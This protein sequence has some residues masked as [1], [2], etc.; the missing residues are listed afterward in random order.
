MRK[1]AA[2]PVSDSA[3]Q[4]FPRMAEVAKLAGVTVM[5][6]SRALRSPEKVAPDTLK[7]IRAAINTT[8][9]VPNALA[10]ALS[11][12]GGSRTITALIP[13]VQHAIFADTITGL[14]TVLRSEGYYLLLGETGYRLEE[15]D[16]LVAAF[17]ARRPE[18]FMLTG[19]THS[20]RTR[21]LLTRT[22]VP[23]VETWE[24][25]NSPIDMVVGYSNEKAAHAMTIWLAG[26]GYRRIAFV[27]GPSRTNER[28][29]RREVGYRRALKELGLRTLR[30]AAI[31]APAA[32]RLEDG[33]AILT[34]VLAEKP[35]AIFFTSDIYAVGAIQEAKR[36]KI[37]VP[38]DLG[39]AG[40]HDLP[41]ASVISPSLTTVHVPS[42]EIGCIAGR[43]IIARI[44]K[45]P[46]PQLSSIPFTI[47]GR[48][49]TR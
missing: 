19:V 21:E 47:I 22:G 42:R 20:S 5:T 26:R 33:A 6:V 38:Q 45:E 36:R 31:G 8:G 29:R 41:I 18:G 14:S 43:N 2:L 23:V 1:R 9:Y 44:R 48:E 39:I 4:S 40:F 46:A 35:D 7:R 10:G 13:T 16:A 11:A 17:L 30:I 27:S 32:P 28:A 15:E 37:G 3:G 12:R 24:L 34:E 25:S 49:S